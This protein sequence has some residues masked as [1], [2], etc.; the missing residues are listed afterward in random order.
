[1]STFESA[2]KD[3]L[4]S[5]SEVLSLVGT[6]IFPGWGGQNQAYPYATYQ[7]TTAARVVYLG[8]ETCAVVRARIQYDIWG[9]TYKSAK[10]I[11]ERF[12]L[13]LNGL[14]GVHGGMRFHL[15]KLDGEFDSVEFPYAGQE[16]AL[17]RVSQDYLVWV[18]EP[19]A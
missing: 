11:A 14:T 19:L 12:R 2:M 8:G 10:D 13:V 15:I 1:M 18:V 3:V 5:D 6:S 17:Y 7:R 4:L 16:E 9:E